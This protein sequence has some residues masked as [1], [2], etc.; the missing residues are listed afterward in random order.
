M[1]LAQITVDQVL[2]GYQNGHS[3]LEASRRITPESERTMLTMS[4]MSGPTMAPGFESYITGYPLPDL[5]CFALA[6]TWLATDMAAWFRLD[7]HAV[8]QGV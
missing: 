7:T 4:D 1:A 6:R 5:Q 8:V 3:L 2:H